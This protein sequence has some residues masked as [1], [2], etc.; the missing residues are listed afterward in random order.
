[1]I[2]FFKHHPNIKPSGLYIWAP[3]QDPQR[4]SILSGVYNTAMCSGADLKKKLNSLDFI[5]YQHAILESP[6]K[7]SRA[8][9]RI[10]DKSSSTRA[11]VEVPPLSSLIHGPLGGRTVTFGTVPSETSLN[12]WLIHRPLGV[13]WP[14]LVNDRS[15]DNEGDCLVGLFSPKKLNEP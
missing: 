5:G 6:V 3:N 11:I 4:G 15:V 13:R 12:C 14:F 10:C 7:L 8:E 9:P 2:S 1:M